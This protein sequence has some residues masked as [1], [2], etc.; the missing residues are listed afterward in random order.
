MGILSH[1]KDSFSHFKVLATGNY[2][3]VFMPLA[4]LGSS[5]F[6]IS[7]PRVFLSTWGKT[8]KL[9]LSYKGDAEVSAYY[10]AAKRCSLLR[11][12]TA[13]LLSHFLMVLTGNY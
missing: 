6:K 1:S 11:Q 7:F 10:P 12:F 5:I 8:V 9:K 13:R 2:G 3:E 4:L